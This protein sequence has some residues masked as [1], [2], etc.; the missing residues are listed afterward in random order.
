MSQEKRVKPCG[1]RHCLDCA[2]M[3]ASSGAD[4][5]VPARRVRRRL[6]RGAGNEARA[7]A[8][9]LEPAL[10]ADGGHVE[11]RCH[12][13]GLDHVHIGDVPERAHPR[14][15]GRHR[16]RAA[17]VI[18]LAHARHR[19]RLLVHQ[20][21][22]RRVLRYGDQAQLR[23]EHVKAPRG[24]H[25]LVQPPRRQRPWPVHGER[26]QL[27]RPA[28]SG[29]RLDILQPQ[30]MGQRPLAAL[31]CRHAILLVLGFGRR[32][33]PPPCRKPYRRPRCESVSRRN[34]TIR[35]AFRNKPERFSLRSFYAKV[36][37]AKHRT[38]TML[39]EHFG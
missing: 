22:K 23:S 26:R 16:Q 24:A 8:Q 28:R 3:R 15:L 2:C 33:A 32:R 17:G 10:V 6:E 35:F 25:T 19:V 1:G 12:G 20:H 4:G 29:Q 37:N 36:E 30:R 38:G 5:F 21:G 11:A 18:R 34:E 27:A 14:Q 31:S 39:L 9:P 13:Q 7:H